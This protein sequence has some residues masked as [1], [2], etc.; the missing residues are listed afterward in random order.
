MSVFVHPDHFEIVHFFAVESLSKTKRG[1][2]LMSVPKRT[3]NSNPFLPPEMLSP[4][5]TMEERACALEK[6]LAAK[7]AEIAAKDA[8][9][10]TR[11]QKVAS[12]IRPAGEAST[13]PGTGPFSREEKGAVCA[14]G[15]GHFL[16]DFPDQNCRRIEI[17][18]A[19]S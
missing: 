3:A 1:S 11:Q 16:A 7:D 6:H 17:S 14:G 12:T 18:A 15:T 2:F 8:Q 13:I 4:A 10:A 5:E 9:V 19:V